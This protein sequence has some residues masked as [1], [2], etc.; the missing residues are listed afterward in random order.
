MVKFVIIA[1]ELAWMEIYDGPKCWRR[2][3]TKFRVYPPD[4][5]IFHIP[6]IHYGSFHL[7]YRY[8]SYST[9]LARITDFNGKHVTSLNL[10]RVCGCGCGCGCVCV[11]ACVRV[12]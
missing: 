9:F 8:A 4:R 3:W 11:C 7:D 10:V 2:V 1:V 12:I 6:H 5:A